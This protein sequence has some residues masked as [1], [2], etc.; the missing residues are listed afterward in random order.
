MTTYVGHVKLANG[1]TI[2]MEVQADST[3]VALQMLRAYGQCNG[4][5]PK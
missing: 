2:L 3:F 4:C 5:S 1:S